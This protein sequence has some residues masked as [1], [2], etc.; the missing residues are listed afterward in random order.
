[1]RRPAFLLSVFTVTFGSLAGLWAC[2]SELP[3]PLTTNI[4]GDTGTPD[5]SPRLDGSPPDTLVPH[6]DDPTATPTDIPQGT[7][8]LFCDLPGTDTPDLTVPDGF[9][10]REFTA[11]TTPIKEARVMRFAPNGDLFVVSPSMGTPGGSIDGLGGIMVLPDDN[12]D[13]VA[14]ADLTFAGPF[15]RGQN[16]C[17]Q[18]EGDPE[19]LSCIHGLLFD[20]GYLYYT[21]SDEGRRI[22]YHA[23]DRLRPTGPSELVAPLLGGGGPEMRWTHTLEKTKAGS[24]YA[25]RGRFDASGC[26]T[27]DMEKGAVLE[28]HIEDTTKAFPLTPEVVGNGFRNP[29]YIRCAPN[30]NGDCYANELTGDGWDGTGAAEKV[31]LLDNPKGTS[32]GFPCC[33]GPSSYAPGS[34]K[35]GFDCANAGQ[36]RVRIPLHDTPFGMDFE[37]GLFPAPYTHG[38]F[39]AIHGVVTSFGGTG[40]IFEPVDP[41]SL[42]PTG[43]A[44]VFV[45]GFRPTGRATDVTFAPDGRM[46]IADD[47]SGRI[48]WVA[49]RTLHMP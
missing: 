36:E 25:S 16:S 19:N 3:D 45:K 26:V 29:M 39:T 47:T 9:C 11:A 27:S 37:R 15:P 31:V 2:S 35:S 10:V 4:G 41:R 18:L 23:G 6:P 30:S 34:N 5:T 17:A 32:W 33:V 12:H 8:P 22:P 7:G 28:L 44:S 43:A 38:I 14:D 40:I 48:F 24:I 1:M 42:R 21:R 46:F 49:P 13:G 20:G